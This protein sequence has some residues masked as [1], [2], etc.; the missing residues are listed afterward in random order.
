MKTFEGY[1]ETTFVM[2][3][4]KIGNTMRVFC[5]KFHPNNQF[6][7]ISGGW[8]NHV[9]VHLFFIILSEELLI[10]FCEVWTLKRNYDYKSPVNCGT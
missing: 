8:D 7:F 6:I 2:D 5:I 9:K 10:M 1:S 3:K 4:T